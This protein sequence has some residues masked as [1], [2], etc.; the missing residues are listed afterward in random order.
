MSWY[1]SEANNNRNSIEYY[2]I[3]DENT[4]QDSSESSRK[5]PEQHNQNTAEINPS[6]QSELKTNKRKST[7][8]DIVK[9]EKKKKQKITKKNFI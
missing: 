1:D 9:K 4:V 6:K 8:K 3:A 2:L 7:T 5:Q